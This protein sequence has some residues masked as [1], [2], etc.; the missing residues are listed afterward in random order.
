MIQMSRRSII[1]AIAVAV[2]VILSATVYWFYDPSTS[3][4]PKCPVYALTGLQCPGCGAQRALH[5]FLHGDFATAWHFNALLFLMVPVVAV[6]AVSEL[7]RNRYPRFNR[8]MT[9]ELTVGLLAVILL[10]WGVVRN[11]F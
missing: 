3:I 4:F 1:I 6:I 9:S 10:V 2:V 5:A 8:A 7:L 11:L